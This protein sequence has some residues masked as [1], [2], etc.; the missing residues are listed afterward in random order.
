MVRCPFCN[1]PM[2]GIESEP[3]DPY[4]DLYRCGACQVEQAVHWGHGERLLAVDQDAET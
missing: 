3:E 1:Q 2:L 4:T